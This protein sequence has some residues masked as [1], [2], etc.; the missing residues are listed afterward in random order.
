MTAYYIK[1]MDKNGETITSK[2]THNYRAFRIFARQRV[3][4]L[5]GIYIKFTYG[6]AVDCYG[7][8][9][10]FTNEGIYPTKKAALMA[11]DAFHEVENV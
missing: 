9:C 1:F 6:R 7:E 4:G 5:G 11:I 2:R 10:L 3:S 8:V